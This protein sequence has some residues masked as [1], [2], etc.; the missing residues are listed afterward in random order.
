MIFIHFLLLF[1]KKIIILY[2]KLKGGCKM[3][4]WPNS[5]E[6]SATFFTKS[7]YDRYNSS[8]YESHNSPARKNPEVPLFD[9]LLSHEENRERKTNEESFNETLRNL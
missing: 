2:L 3:S 6:P 1:N 7:A 4:Q 8:E 5:K 9:A